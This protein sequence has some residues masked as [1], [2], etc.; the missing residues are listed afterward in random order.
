M[1]VLSAMSSQVG[2]AAPPSAPATVTHASGLLPMPAVLAPQSD[3]VQPDTLAWHSIVE[4]THTSLVGQNSGMHGVCVSTTVSCVVQSV[5]AAGRATLAVAR[6]TRD[7]AHPPVPG[8]T[9]RK[10][11]VG[12]PS[13]SNIFP[14]RPT[15]LE[16]ACM[17]V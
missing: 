17:M 15:S 3:G 6:T 5:A 9:T 13:T 10:A 14:Y 1:Y 8:S 4:M 2:A 11:T 7:F 12:L 16:A